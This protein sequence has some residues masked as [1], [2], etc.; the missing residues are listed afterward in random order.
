[1]DNR[2]TSGKPDT[3][4]R[5]Y[6]VGIDGEIP[7]EPF[8]ALVPGSAVPLLRVDLPKA[9]RGP[10]RERVARRQINDRAGQQTNATDIRPFST[11]DGNAE[12]TRVLVADSAQVENWR[13][14]FSAASKNCVALLPDYLALSAADDVWTIKS[15]SGQTSARLGPADGFSAETDMASVLLG[16]ALDINAPKAVLFVGP[17]VKDIAAEFKKRKIPTFN[18][19]EKL[20]QQDFQAPRAF[21]F[22]ELAADLMQNPELAAEQLR[23]VLRAWRTPVVLSLLA[24]V[25]WSAAAIFTSGDTAKQERDFRDQALAIV[26]DVFVPSGPILDIRSQV[27]VALTARKDRVTKAQNNVKPLALFKS[28]AVILFVQQATITSVSY[29]ADSDLTVEFLVRDFSA[30]DQLVAALRAGGLTVRLAESQAGAI[31]GGTDG[32]SGLLVINS[33][34]GTR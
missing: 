20:T 2:L 8:V 33:N 16:K 23:A 30:A 17:A 12:W 24:L 18:S 25:F 13:Q 11:T 22:K 28:T 15:V 19:A 7:S 14:Q 3:Q 26:R 6:H 32:V 4:L 1:M 21:S 34:P 5:L 10:A 9:L 27:N 31:D 29:S